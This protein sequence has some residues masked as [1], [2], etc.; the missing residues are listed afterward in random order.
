MGGA[1]RRENL[2]N[3]RMIHLR[4]TI[5]TK[6]MKGTYERWTTSH[7]EF[8]MAVEI[9]GA[10]RQVS[11]FDGQK[12]WAVDSSGTPHELSGVV[13]RSVVSNAYEASDSYLFAGRIPGHVELVGEDPNHEAYVLKLEPDDGNPSTVYLDK[14]TFLPLREETAGPLG[15]RTIRFSTWRDSSGVNMP[16]VILQSNG[17]LSSI[18]ITTNTLGQ[19]LRL[20]PTCSPHHGTPAPVRF[21]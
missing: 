4:G 5:E 19:A 17:V 13:L 16:R 12:G 18:T 3:V 8:R 14:Q 21:A 2:Q 15:N 6:G 9:S 7:G 20:P 11:I 1:W 10:F